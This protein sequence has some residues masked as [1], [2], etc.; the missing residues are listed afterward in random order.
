[1]IPVYYNPVSPWRKT[2]PR[3]RASWREDSI[4]TLHSFFGIGE[5]ISSW[6]SSLSSSRPS[7]SSLL[8]AIGLVIDTSGTGC[9][10]VR[11]KFAGGLI[12]PAFPHSGTSEAGLLPLLLGFLLGLLLRLLLGSHQHSTPFR[13][14]RSVSSGLIVKQAD[15]Y[16]SAGT[17]ASTS[18]WSVR[19]RASE[20]LPHP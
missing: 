20:T 18:P 6:L 9:R 8:P 4:R 7:C 2:K 3:R 11:F 19:S 1:M 5:V 17:S 12:A 13:L 10:A 16:R 14:P 15:V